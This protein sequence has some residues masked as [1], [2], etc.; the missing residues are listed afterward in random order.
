MI[1][2]K[3]I[4]LVLA[5]LVGLFAARAYF[6][7]LLASGALHSYG[8]PGYWSLLGLPALA[9]FV[10]FCAIAFRRRKV[11]AGWIVAGVT[12]LAVVVAYLGLFGDFL[13]C[14]F[15]TRGACE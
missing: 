6:H 15:V 9:L 2:S 11:A 12:L 13:L 3:P 8:V 5:T 4:Q 14:V 10:P 7:W 1:A